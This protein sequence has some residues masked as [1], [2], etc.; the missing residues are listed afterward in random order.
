MS[1]A[2]KSSTAIELSTVYFCEGAIPHTLSLRDCGLALRGTAPEAMTA[3]Y[4]H[5]SK[6]A[7]FMAARDYAERH[8]LNFTVI[9]F[10]VALDCRINAGQ[11][12]AEEIRE[13]D[14]LAFQRLARSGT[15]QIS[16]LLQEGGALY[17]EAMKPGAILLERPELLSV[18]LGQPDLRHLK[19]VAFQAH[20]VMSERA[21]T[22]GAVPY[23][24][25]RAITEATCRLN[26]TTRITLDPPA[27]VS[28]PVN[29]SA[30]RKKSAPRSK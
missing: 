6:Q 3:L 20:P 17:A 4:G 12:K 1:E 24:H 16:V 28:A 8:R 5:Q 7:G 10:L 25:W 22:I 13:H 27:P 23:S 2:A 9:D 19:V 18:L 21:L 15:D 30:P 26:P 14:F 11:M 29:T